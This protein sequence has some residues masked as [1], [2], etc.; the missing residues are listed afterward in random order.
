MVV[1]EL[2]SVCPH[3]QRLASCPMAHKYRSVCA[4]VFSSGPPCGFVHYIG[5]GKLR[6]LIE[7]HPHETFYVMNGN[8]ALIKRVKFEEYLDQA[9]AV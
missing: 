3:W 1:L 2:L 7:E 9:T 4:N 6:S 8:R 5:E